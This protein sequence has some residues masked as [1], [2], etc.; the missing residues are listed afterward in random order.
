MRIGNVW[1]ITSWAGEAVYRVSANGKS[2][3]PVVE[4]LPSPAD[5]GYDPTRNWLIVPSPFGNSVT[6]VALK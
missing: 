5:L 3:V 2:V 1:Y 6:F 4:D